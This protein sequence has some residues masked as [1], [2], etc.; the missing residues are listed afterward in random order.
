MRDKAHKCRLIARLKEDYPC[1]C[2]CKMCIADEVVPDQVTV[3][4]REKVLHWLRYK[5][6]D[7]YKLESVAQEKAP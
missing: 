7:E 6:R 5:E 2:F 3:A 4:G 1:P